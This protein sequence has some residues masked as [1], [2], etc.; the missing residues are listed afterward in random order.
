MAPATHFIV[1]GTYLGTSLGTFAGIYL[2]SFLILGH[3]PDQ[4]APNEVDSELFI[5]VLVESARLSRSS[6]DIFAGTYPFVDSPDEGDPC[7]VHSVRLRL[8][9][10]QLFLLLR[11]GPRSHDYFI[12]N[13][14]DFV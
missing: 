13:V 3:S 12:T 9:H 5:Q 1:S 2:P 7:E 4:D 14:F 8:R 6:L 10:L 11:A